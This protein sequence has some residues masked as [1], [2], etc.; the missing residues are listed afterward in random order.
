MEP[1]H[2]DNPHTP[3]SHPTEDMLEAYALGRLS[4][5][6]LGGIE[7]HLFICDR[8][9]DALVQTEEY[10]TAMKAA[11]VEPLA[12][13]APKSLANLWQAVSGQFADALRFPRPL[14]LFTAALAALSL[15]AMLSQIYPSNPAI[16]EAEITLRSI[17]G[18]AD[19][20]SHGPAES[21]LSLK[22]ESQHLGLNQSFQARIVDA[23]GKP[24]W[25]GAPEFNPNSGYILRVDN[26]LKAGTYWVRLY[27]TDQQ[28]L[29][30]YGLKLE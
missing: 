14:P 28:L 3:M 13:P 19:S 22:I 23:A 8:C 12:E 6:Q 16:K 18:G 1:N 5:P 26:P 4:E 29:Q 2:V 27:D 11:L 21:R 20:Q 25:K 9:Q 7:T 24:A 10:V 30:E 15:A 17:R